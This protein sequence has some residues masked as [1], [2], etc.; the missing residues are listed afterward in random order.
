M[1][2]IFFCIVVACLFS[3]CKKDYACVCSNPGG[4]Y[5]A[6]KVKASTK[7]AQAK[8]DDYYATN[9][10]AVPWNETLCEIR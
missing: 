2:R 1:A 10:G 6:F 9:F 8:C 4:E 3:A 5:T 7:Q